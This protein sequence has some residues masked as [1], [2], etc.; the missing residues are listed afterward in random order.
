[1]LTVEPRT[2]L[3]KVKALHVDYLSLGGSILTQLIFSGKTSI[4]QS[5]ADR[6]YVSL[7]TAGTDPGYGPVY[8]NVPWQL[9]NMPDRT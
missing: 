5:L 6:V 3:S 2:R 7:G 1:M 8:R 4:T 9:S